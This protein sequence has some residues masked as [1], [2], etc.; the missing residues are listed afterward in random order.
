MTEA[1]GYALGQWQPL[2]VF[3]SDG[4]VPI[5]NNASQREMKRIV[6]SRKSSLFV[7]NPCAGRTAAI[8][9]S[10]TP[11]CRRLDLVP[12]TYPLDSSWSIHQHASRSTRRL[13]P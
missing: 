10:L 6:L 7:G 1:I 9:A 2:S 11:I 8:L 3:C 13:A 12:H 5:D 4:A